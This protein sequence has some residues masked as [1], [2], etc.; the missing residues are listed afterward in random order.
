MHLTPVHLHE[1]RYNSDDNSFS[2]EREKDSGRWNL[3]EYYNKT[4]KKK[5]KNGGKNNY[6]KPKWNYQQSSYY[7]SRQGCNFKK[8]AKFSSC[9]RKYNK[10]SEKYNKT[11]GHT[12]DTTTTITHAFQP[13]VSIPTSPS[14]RPHPPLHWL[15]PFSLPWKCRNNETIWRQQQQRHANTSKTLLNNRLTLLTRIS[16]VQKAGRTYLLFIANTRVI[17]RLNKFI[18]AISRQY[19]GFKKL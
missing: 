2:V 10:T 6:I 5:K 15:P 1:N 14:P 11:A 18:L 16:K 4:H 17:K 9:N 13:P 7:R 12:T 8:G 3:L 19:R